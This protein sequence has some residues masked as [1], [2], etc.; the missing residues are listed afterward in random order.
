MLSDLLEQRGPSDYVEEL[1]HIVPQTLGFARSAGADAEVGRGFTQLNFVGRMEELGSA[2]AHVLS[3][4]GA[5]PDDAAASGQVELHNAQENR[6]SSEVHEVQALFSTSA[7]ASGAGESVHAAALVTAL[8][9]LLTREYIC[10]GYTLPERCA[11]T[12][13]KVTMGRR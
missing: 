13:A 10:L 9:N 8:C 6:R 7:S 11:A 1:V 12:S 5:T 4:L 3:D 2:W